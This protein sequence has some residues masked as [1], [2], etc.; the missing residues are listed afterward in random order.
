MLSLWEERCWLFS[1]IW[2]N[3]PNPT[4]ACAR[5]ANLAHWC[6]SLSSPSAESQMVTLR[7]KADPDR[8]RMNPDVIPTAFRDYPEPIPRRFR[9]YPNE[10]P[11]EFRDLS[12]SWRVSPLDFGITRKKFGVTSRIT[13]RER[14]GI[15]ISVA[16]RAPFGYGFA[17][18]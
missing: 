3:V 18:L 13:C 9:D 4:A 10:I 2:E 17:F 1:P 8:S 11:T 15:A 12:G 7:E 16:A 5:G 6:A 14:R